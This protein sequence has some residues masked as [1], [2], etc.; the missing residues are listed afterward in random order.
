MENSYELL[1]NKTKII[2]NKPV[3]FISTMYYLANEELF[4]VLYQELQY[5]PKKE[6]NEW[7]DLMKQSLSPFLQKELKFF[8]GMENT[9]EVKPFIEYCFSIKADES[10]N[11]LLLIVEEKGEKKLIDLL[12][13]SIPNEELRDEL[14]EISK[15]QSGF[16]VLQEKLARIRPNHV[17]MA[18][19][20]LEECIKDPSEALQRFRFLI[21]GLYQKNFLPIEKDI[22]EKC[23]VG[24]N[25]YSAIFKENPE[26][27]FKNFIKFDLKNFTKD[28]VII[29]SYFTPGP[30]TILTNS[31]KTADWIILGIDTDRLFKNRREKELVTR[32]IKAISDERRM[33][34]IQLLSKRPYYGQELAIL[35]DLTP[36]AI[37]YH[38]NF[39]HDLDLVKSERVDHRIYYSINK[40]LIGTMFDLCK[41]SILE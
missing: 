15:S 25:K 20:R 24:I 27:L 7:L 28:I 11:D 35:L 30:Y 36:A 14:K 12:I 16:E 10:I 3:E 5:K 23:I 40:E 19:T 32:F 22:F 31:M 26:A 37:S 9:N 29:I 6:F 39:L 34:L 33:K 4:D 13:E 38:F 17:S 2:I 18:F 8:F 21:N 1:V 41:K